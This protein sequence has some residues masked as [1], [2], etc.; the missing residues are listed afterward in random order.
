MSDRPVSSF[1]FDATKWTRNDRITG[2]ATL[3][4]FIALF[5]PWFGVSVGARGFGISVEADGLTAHGYLYIVLIL[6]L[7]LMGYLVIR[8]GMADLATKLPVGH[9]I[10]IMGLTAVNALLVILAFVFK[11]GGGAVGWRWGAFV[12]LVAAIVALA[13]LGLPYVQARRAKPKG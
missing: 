7:V 5:L 2:I 9:E 10:L 12:A 6:A 13:P 3:V 11:P 4:L 1:K 8:A